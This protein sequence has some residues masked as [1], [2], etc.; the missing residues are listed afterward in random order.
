MDT[1]ETSINMIKPGYYMASVDLTDAYYTVPIDPS[2]QKY[3][4]F[5][6][7]GKYFQYT[8]LPNGLAS[9]PRIFTKLLNP[10]YSTLRSAGHFRSVRST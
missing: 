6:F 2:H 7:D 9:A 10:V 8:S 3:L 1:L 5:C 4:K